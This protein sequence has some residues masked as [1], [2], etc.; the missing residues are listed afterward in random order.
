MV[1]YIAY[2]DAGGIATSDGSATSYSGESIL[3]APHEL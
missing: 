3:N 1:G 2:F